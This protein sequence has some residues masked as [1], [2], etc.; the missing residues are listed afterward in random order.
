M[1]IEFRPDAAT[2]DLAERTASVV[3]QVVIPV[4]LE[5]H[6]SLHHGP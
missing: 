6:G 5:Y 3:R 1:P 2:R 4:E